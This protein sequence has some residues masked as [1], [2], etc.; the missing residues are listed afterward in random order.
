VRHTSRT[1]RSL[2]LVVALAQVAALAL[3][4]PCACGDEGDRRVAG[5]SCGSAS[6]CCAEAHAAASACCCPGRGADPGGPDAPA[7]GGDTARVASCTA[8]TLPG[9]VPAAALS[10]AAPA[11]LLAPALPAALLRSPPAPE[12]PGA[13]A[14]RSERSLPLSIRLTR[15]T[16]LLS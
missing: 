10:H 7:G 9:T 16:V 14:R 8:G 6:A 3:A 5:P 1:T 15:T 4:H 12:A 11:G 2:G 13:V